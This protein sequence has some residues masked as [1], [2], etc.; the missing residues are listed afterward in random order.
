M[1]LTPFRL[2][3]AAFAAAL[4][5]AAGAAAPAPLRA[6][7][8]LV[9]PQGIVIDHR[10]RSGSFELYNPG[11]EAAEV[12]VATL[13][14]YPVSDSTG[15]TTLA[16][17]E[18][19]DSTQPSAAAW[20]QAYPRRLTLRPS[21]RQTV[22][23]FAKPPAN[24][25]DGEYWTRLVV[26][27]RGAPLAVSGLGDTT[28]MHAGL[29]LEVRTIVAAWYRKGAVQ[30][31]VE[32][33]DVQAR[34]APARDS[35]E[36]RLRFHRQGNAAYIGTARGSLVNAAGKEVGAFTSQLAVYYD[37]EPRY[38]IPVAALPPGRYTLRLQA[39]VER[40]D[41]ARTAVVPGNVAR[42]SVDVV[43]PARAG[44]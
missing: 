15:R 24:L 33:S 25:P 35:L 26:T 40:A 10:T 13:F 17:F 34:V 36:V 30:T 2:R 37:L 38:T 41:L 31:A 7:G 11:T 43:I 27:A 42:Q 16:M 22:R 20:V 39:D 19:P 6:Q 32:M 1:T 14:G 28:A 21:E 5:A 23:L 4:L 12:T 9:A 8:V 3:R 29:T 44:N 18:S